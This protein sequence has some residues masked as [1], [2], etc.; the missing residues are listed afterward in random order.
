MYV[1][2]C[3]DSFITMTTQED[4]NKLH[5]LPLILIICSQLLAMGRKPYAPYISPSLILH[6]IHDCDWFALHCSCTVS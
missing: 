2:N 4:C 1:L 6:C 5:K 3:V